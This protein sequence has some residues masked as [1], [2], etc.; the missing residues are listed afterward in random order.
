MNDFIKKNRKKKIVFL[1]IP[2]LIES[3]LMRKF[4]FIIFIK[5]KKKIRLKRFLA[6]GGNKK[7]FE[8]LNKKQLKDSVK[9]KFCDFVVVNDKN[10]K[11]LKR[12]LF[13]IINK[14]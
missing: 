7:L 5:T 11:I 8:L 6:T 4:D 12:N 3:K 13:C 10:I 2:L 14:I 1:E 9:V